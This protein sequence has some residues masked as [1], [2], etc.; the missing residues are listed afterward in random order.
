MTTNTVTA[1]MNQ[2]GKYKCLSHEEMLEI[3]RQKKAA[4]D[5]TPEYRRL[6]N[7]LVVHNLKLV[8]NFVESYMLNK[9]CFNYGDDITN[10]YLQQGVLALIRAAEKYDP[11]MNFC[12]STYAF[13]W[14]RSRIGRYALKQSTSFHMSEADMRRAYQYDKHQRIFDGTKNW[15]ANPEF[16][17]ALVRSAQ[18]AFSIYRPIHDSSLSLIDLIPAPPQTKADPSKFSLVIEDAMVA[19]GLTEFQKEAL[20]CIYID[21]RSGAE[22]AQEAGMTDAQFKMAKSR[23]IKKLRRTTSADI[24]GA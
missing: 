10:D 14:L 7:K 6:V 8:I 3:A 23:A 24:L 4:G 19:A 11:D 12:F 9:V 20:R 16:N 2:A 21:G 22:V 5:D 1:W 13:H 18:N 17:A 15:S